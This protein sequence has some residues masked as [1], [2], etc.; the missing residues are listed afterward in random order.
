METFPPIKASAV[1]SNSILHIPNI[2]DE[3]YHNPETRKIPILA[4]PLQGLSVTQLFHL[5]KG[6]VPDKSICHQKPTAV[7]YSS[8]FVMDLSCVSCLDDL[9]ADDNGV[10]V[11]GGNRIKNTVWN[12][13]K[14]QIRY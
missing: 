4:R 5:M 14:I 1:T 6:T 11:H 2:C 9:R 3:D 8:V 10:W 13:M 12:L 7:R